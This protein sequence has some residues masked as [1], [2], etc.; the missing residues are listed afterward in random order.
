[1]VA[2][3]ALTDMFRKRL[4]ITSILRF[5]RI[6]VAIKNMIL[7]SCKIDW[8]KHKRKREDIFNFKPNFI[9]WTF[10]RLESSYYQYCVNLGGAI[11]GNYLLILFKKS[12]FSVS[13]LRSIYLLY[14]TSVKERPRVES[15]NILLNIKYWIRSKIEC[16]C[17]M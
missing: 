8:D 4:E 16:Y 11:T 1:M 2:K 13:Y 14:F 15:Q 7:I 17:H 10:I 3:S 12:I 6:C 5:C 9:T